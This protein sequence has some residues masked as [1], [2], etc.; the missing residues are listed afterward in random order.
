M[1]IA[2]VAIPTSIIATFGLIWYQGFTLNSMTMLALDPVGGYRHRRCDCRARE[3]LSVRRGK[4]AAAGTGGRRSHARDWPRGT[5]DD[6][7]VDCHLRSYRFHGRHRRSLHDE[8]WLD[9]V[10]CDPRVAA[11]QLYIDADDGRALDQDASAPRGRQRPRNHRTGGLEG[12]TVLPAARSRLHGHAAMVAGASRRDCRVSRYSCC[13]AACRC[14][15]WRTRT[16]CPNDDQSEFEVGL[17]APEGT[18]LDATE[19]IGNRLAARI[20]ELPEVAYTLVSVADDP[21]RTQNAEPSTS[22]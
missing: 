6:A 17:R 9:D 15:C 16:S 7:L 8:L 18:S 12:F 4:G 13:S 1:I 10:L 11:R 3:H 20:R 19:I 14:S 21:A 2:A 22:A 5:G